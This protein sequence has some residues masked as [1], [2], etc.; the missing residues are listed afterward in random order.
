MKR[1]DRSVTVEAGLE[2]A[3]SEL[4]LLGARS[5]YDQIRALKLGVNVEDTNAALQTK[6][7]GSAY[8]HLGLG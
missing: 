6:D 4:E 2:S 8:L 3:D 1:S 5:S 7:A